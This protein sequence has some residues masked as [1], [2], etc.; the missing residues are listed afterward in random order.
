MSYYDHAVLMAL[1]LGPWADSCHETQLRWRHRANGWRWRPGDIAA[2]ESPD[3]ATATPAASPS[4]APAVR[5]G[6]VER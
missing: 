2:A 3:P 1:R 6:A 5:P 4:P